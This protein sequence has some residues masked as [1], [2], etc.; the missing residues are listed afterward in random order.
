MPRFVQNLPFLNFAYTIHAG[1]PSS[2]VTQ[3]EW[4]R[5]SEMLLYRAFEADADSLVFVESDKNI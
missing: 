2:P 5:A 1:S 3:E 4:N